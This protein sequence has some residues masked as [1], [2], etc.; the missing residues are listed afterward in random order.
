MRVQLTPEL[1]E[2]IAGKVES[3]LYPSADEV[4]GQALELLEARDRQKAELRAKIAAGWASLRAGKGTDALD[5]L[6]QMIA[7]MK[8][9]GDE[10]ERAKL[11]AAAA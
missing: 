4:M 9:E 5:F 1:E 2:K 7:E 6:D 10:A 3:G 8:A 11:E